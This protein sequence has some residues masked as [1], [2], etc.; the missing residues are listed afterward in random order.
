MKEK[1]NGIWLFAGLL[2]IAVAIAF[3]GWVIW[4]QQ[5]ALGA[6]GPVASDMKQRVE[7]RELTALQQLYEHLKREYVNEP[8][9]SV[10][11]QGAMEGMVSALGDPRSHYFDADQMRTQG[12]Q[13][14]GS[15]T[16]IGSTV[17]SGV[18]GYVT[19]IFIYP[20]SPAERAGLL[21]GDKLLAIDGVDAQGMPLTEAVTRVKGP[22]G[23]IVKLTI[24]RPSEPEPFEVDI[25]R[26]VVELISV[27]A[28]MLEDEVGLITI[29]TFN[30]ST[31]AQFG[32]ELQ[33]LLDQGMKGLILD[34]RNNGGGTLDGLM[35]VANMLV[36]AGT[37]FTW[38]FRNQIPQDHI[39]TLATRNFEVVVLVNGYSA[40]ASEVLAGALQDTG[41]GRLVGVR[42]FGKG[43]AQ[44]TY[45][46]ANGGGVSF[47]VS[48]WVTPK[49]RYIEGQGLEPDV[50]AIDPYFPLVLE[51]GRL[52]KPGQIELL[53][54]K[55]Q[56][57]GF[58]APFEE[59]F[60]EKTVAAL[61]AFQEDSR[62]Y[63]SGAL[64]DDTLQVLNK[65][66]YEEIP[67]DNDPQMEIALAEIHKLI[68][69]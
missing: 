52:I 24:L 32:K 64:S 38:T 39:S 4:Q 37:V 19:M 20:N 36:P 69:R 12:E 48:H 22:R 59:G 34:I 3:N 68:A 58:D 16:G 57:L 45:R 41:A 5:I 23:T 25:V 42:T 43:S 15:Y 67:H 46:L 56:A 49:G 63:V 6:V 14:S 11:L 54:A 33:R 17:E 26:D 2:L 40:S 29:T 60:G 10:L 47:T 62:I 50:K 51:K 44:H 13:S 66:C 35:D 30:D 1:P 21:S 18:D 9:A 61:Q 55:L 65:R 7:E 27:T 31:G 28:K 53:Q 8:D